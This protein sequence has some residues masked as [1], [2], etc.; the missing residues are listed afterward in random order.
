M[1]RASMMIFLLAFFASHSQSPE[2]YVYQVKGDVLQKKPNGQAAPV[3]QRSLV[4]K[5]DEVILKKDAAIT[6][7]NKQQQNL[8]LA[9]AGIY[10]VAEL[11]KKLHIPNT[12]MVKKYLGMLWDELLVPDYRFAKPKKQELA[13]SW[14]GLATRGDLCNNRVFPINGLKTADDSL[15]F[16]WLATSPSRSYELQ[17]LNSDGTEI[18]NKIVRDTQVLLPVKEMVQ[19]KNGKYYWLVKS[20]DGTCEDEVPFYFDVLSKEDETKLVQGLLSSQP[21]GE[22]LARLQEIDKLEKQALISA[23]STYFQ[24]LVNEYPDNKAL[25][26]SYA[27]FLLKYGFEAEADLLLK[28]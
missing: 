24:K 16:R 6:L 28:E 15:H 25:K 18:T 26:K 5:A 10:K 23:A 13:A 4:Y 20:N 11:S 14:G 3:K 2:Y 9:S 8:V 17:L 27:S 1:K 22:I 21:D 12:G 7:V 19:N